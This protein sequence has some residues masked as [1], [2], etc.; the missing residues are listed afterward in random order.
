MNAM[1]VAFYPG[2][3]TDLAPAV[4]FPGIKTWW[5]MDGQPRSEHGDDPVFYRPDFLPRLNQIMGQCGFQLQCEDGAMRR[6]YSAST[7]QTI[8][9]E[10]STLFPAAWDPVKHAAGIKNTLVLCGY[11]I[12]DVV[13]PP[14]FLS[15]YSHIITDSITVHTKHA[16]PTHSVSR[17]KYPL[18]LE[19]WMTEHCTTGHFQKYYSY[20]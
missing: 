2:A 15:S 11:D 7:D 20:V 17:I 12:D 1:H 6:Y 3:G 8:H 4:L 14:G 9:Y 19:Y 18:D 10:T 13:L 16:L 5:Y